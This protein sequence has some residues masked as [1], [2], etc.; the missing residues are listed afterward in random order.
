[1]NKISH[2]SL[3]VMAAAI[4]GGLSHSALA[5]PQVNVK[6]YGFVN[7]EIEAV[8]AEGGATP[9]DSRGRISDG[10]SRIGFSGSIEI[11]PDIQ[12][13]WQIEGGLN[14]FE[15]GGVNSKGSTAIID[16]RN[17]FVGITGSGF[18][19]FIIG[20]N[21]SVYR[22]L[23]G[24]GSALGG[25]LGLKVHG[26]DVLNN[27]TAQLSG[28][29]DSIFGRGE[30]R[31]KNSVHYLS[32]E[33]AGVQLGA[34]FGLDEAQTDLSDHSR[35]SV[36]LKYTLGDFS[37]GAGYDHQTNTGVDTDRLEQGFGFVTNAQDDVDTSYYKVMA[38][39]K[40]PTQ[41]SVGIGYEVSEYGFSEIVPP[42]NSNIFSSLQTGTMK[43]NAAIISV[44]QDI[45]DASI[46]LGYGK[47]GD[48]TDTSF[49]TPD[50]FSAT[51]VS[52]GATY[53]MNSML[54]SYFYYTKIS[55]EP[56]ANVNFGQSP[57]YSNND[58][59]DSAFLAPGNSPSAIGVGI[60]AR[61]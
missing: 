29:A 53:N 49:T 52:F 60:L 3:S 41:T 12:G 13:I 9:Y 32:P 10:N 2:F 38:S 25:N 7:G 36:A 44:A 24:S 18:G 5:D 39:Y 40:L 34:S 22:S 35:Y 51:Q 14:N 33:M 26:V 30:S 20:Y 1:M 19:R 61:F 4:L 27:T 42:T 50:A 23:I 6:T 8:K 11:D 55:N 56:Q 43:Q 21:D 58:G 45:G 57:I 28:N 31:Y 15:Q 54:T 16:S 46:M 17:T 48:L 59:T 37:V 47:L